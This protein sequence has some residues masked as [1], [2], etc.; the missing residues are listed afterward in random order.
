MFIRI[1]RQQPCAEGASIK[2][3][4]GVKAGVAEERAGREIAAG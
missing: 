2:R 1:A 3:K 4:R